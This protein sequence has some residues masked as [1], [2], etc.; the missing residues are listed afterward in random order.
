VTLNEASTVFNLLPYMEQEN[1]YN[2]QSGLPFRSGDRMMAAKAMLEMPIA[3][4]NC[5]SRRAAALYPTG[6]S[7]P[8]QIMPKYSAKLTEVARSDYA[9]NGGTLFQDALFGGNGF[10]YWGPPS[11]EVAESDA[12]QVAWEM[13][14]NRANGVFYPGSELKIADI[15]D[16]T[17]HTYM[18]GEKYMNADWYTTGYDAGD[19]E[20]MLMGDNGDITRWAGEAEN[21]PPKQDT[22]GYHHWRLFGSAHAGTFNMVF[23]DGGVRPIA[24]DIDLVIHGRL[25]NRKDGVP[26]DY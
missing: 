13:I 18:F 22:P 24:Y 26:V 10:T 5:P 17:T 7:G 11:I 20:Y 9:S 12:G 25:A 4:F 8:M 15:E 19:N 23:C 3:T 6:F 16:G 2:L 1:V 14:A 21:Y